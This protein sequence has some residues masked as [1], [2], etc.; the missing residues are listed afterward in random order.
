[1]MIM[2]KMT[3]SRGVG[4]VW[5]RR[6]WVKLLLNFYSTT[7]APTIQQSISSS[8]SWLN[9]KIIINHNNIIYYFIIYF[10]II[11]IYFYYL[12]KIAATRPKECM[13]VDGEMRVLMT[14]AIITV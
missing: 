1:M 11:H 9:L 13:S 14:G 6:L 5:G 4:A 12:K 10:L 3:G 2:I 8:S 7:T